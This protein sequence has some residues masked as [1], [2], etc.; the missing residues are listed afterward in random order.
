MNIAIDA[1]V[2]ASDALASDINHAV[3]KQFLNALAS[4][5]PTVYCPTLVIVETVAADAPLAQNAINIVS[6]TPG[7]NLV[8]LTDARALSA[9]QTAIQCRL[10]GADACYVAVA[11]E[12][13]ATLVTW[14]AEMLQRGA[15][16]VT[17]QT[18]ADWLTRNPPSPPPSSSTP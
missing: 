4:V 3:S 2:F 16:A 13:G 14:D 10:R 9:A 8:A 17:T 6:Q 7:M 15:N 5:S 11:A 12:F 18:P 1:S